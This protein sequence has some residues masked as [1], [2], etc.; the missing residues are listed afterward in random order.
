MVAWHVDGHKIPTWASIIVNNADLGT[1]T[2]VIEAQMVAPST[3]RSALLYFPCNVAC[4]SM[5][6][7]LPW[8]LMSLTQEGVTAG[9]H[10]E[11][12]RE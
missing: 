8:L 2:L 7:V 12:E 10:V 6:A 9:K 5:S 11:E 1:P 3:C 4:I